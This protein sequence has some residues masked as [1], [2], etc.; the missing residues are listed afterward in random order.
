MASNKNAKSGKGKSTVEKVYE[1]VKPITDEL[2]LLLWD[3]TFEKEGAYWY[4][5]VFIDKSDG[6]MPGIE[7]CENVTRPLSKLLDDIDPIEQSYILEVG[8]PGLGRELKTAE[9]FECCMDCPVRIRFIRETSDGEKEIIAQLK[10]YSKD[11]IKVEA[12]GEERIVKLAE[13]AYVRLYD[14]EDIFDD[15]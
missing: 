6:S 3:I 5:R 13:T 10:E 2:D 7:D 9:H 4:L 12:D 1:L 11:S 15:E 14:D 8:S